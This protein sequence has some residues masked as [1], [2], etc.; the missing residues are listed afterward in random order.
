MPNPIDLT[1]RRFGR[2]TAIR[3]VATGRRR[4]WLCMCDCGGV[5]TVATDNL[6]SG[7]STSCVRCRYRNAKGTPK[8][9]HRTSDSKTSP[10]Y[11]TWKAMKRRVFSADK[12]EYAGID[13]DPRWNDFP[14]FL[15]DMGERPDGMTVD[16]EDNSLGY[17]KHNCRWA[18]PTQQT[19]NRRNTVLYEFNGRLLPIADW[20]NELGITW[21]AAYKR[22]RENGSLTPKINRRH[23]RRPLAHATTSSTEA[24]R[25]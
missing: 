12:P 23:G 6:R 25:S 17:W 3:L 8:H 13:M 9:G 10:T 7:N 20:A 22:I 11:Q 24:K 2:L 14:A 18:T 21:N 15:A 1:G 5:A 16:R 19:R 4:K